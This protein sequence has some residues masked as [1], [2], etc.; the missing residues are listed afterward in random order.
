MKECLET[1]VQASKHSIMHF[2]GLYEHPAKNPGPKLES[3]F[4][5]L[6]NRKYPLVKKGTLP[7]PRQT[8]LY[9]IP[10][11][12]YLFIYLFIYL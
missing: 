9:T 2:R 10:M 11:Y 6:K 8:S 7:P 1:L 5:W 12:I 4:P 3:Q